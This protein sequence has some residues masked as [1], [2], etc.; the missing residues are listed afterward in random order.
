MIETDLKNLKFTKTH[1]WLSIDGTQGTVGITDHAQQE[2]TDIVFVELPKPGKTV[3]HGE[4]VAV[5]ESV[6]A[7]F[8]I[9]APVSGRVAKVNDALSKN[10]AILNRSPYKEGWIFVLEVKDPSEVK[11][12]LDHEQYD[13]W[14]KGGGGH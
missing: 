4:E 13:Q 2:I 14:V 12:L 5:V 9:Y 8:S 6:K 11:N 1:E 7:A 3:A 10:P